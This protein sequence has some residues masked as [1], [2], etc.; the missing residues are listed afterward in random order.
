MVEVNAMLMR[1]KPGQ[2]RRQRRP[3]HTHGNITIDKSSRFRSQPIN[4][5]SVHDVVT[6]EAEV[7][8]TVIICQ[9]HD[10]VGAV[11]Q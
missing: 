8:V 6:K 11:V 9:N 10:H 5:G 7:S 4:I 1:I 3:A 2:Q